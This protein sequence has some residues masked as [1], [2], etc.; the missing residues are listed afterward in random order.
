MIQIPLQTVPNQ[1]LS[2][3][4]DD[5]NYDF[6]IRSMPG[7]ST[8]MVF[9]IT[10]DNELIVEGVRAVPAYPLIEYKYLENG[11][12]IVITE[13]DDY[14][15]WEKFQISQFLLYASNAEIEAIQNGTST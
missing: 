9:D 15:D 4:L 3:Q 14:P 12:F 6:E 10:I 5:V 13:N 11:N 1:S 2:I 8:I 7:T